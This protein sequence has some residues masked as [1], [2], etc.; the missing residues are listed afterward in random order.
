M[1]QGESEKRK[2]V[3]AVPYLSPELQMS[4]STFSLR[5]AWLTAMAAVASRIAVA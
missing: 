4:T 5:S 3:G 2:E 1:K